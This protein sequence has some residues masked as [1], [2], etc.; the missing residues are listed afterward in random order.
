MIGLL[1]VLVGSGCAKLSDLESVIKK[2]SIEAQSQ[3]HAEESHKFC[4]DQIQKRDTHFTIPLFYQAIEDSFSSK[5]EVIKR[6]EK[7]HQILVRFFLKR[8]AFILKKIGQS[9]KSIFFEKNKS[10]LEKNL[11]EKSREEQIELMVDAM[12]LED[13]SCTTV[14]HDLWITQWIQIFDPLHTNGKAKKIQDYYRVPKNKIARFSEN[15]DRYFVAELNLLDS[16]QV[17]LFINE[18]KKKKL[19]KVVLDLRGAVSVT[20]DWILDFVDFIENNF[21][22]RVLIRTNLWTRGW[23]EQ[24][25]YRLVQTPNVWIVGKHQT[26]LGMTRKFCTLGDYGFGCDSFEKTGPDGVGILSHFLVND[27]Q[28]SSPFGSLRRRVSLIRFGNRSL[29]LMKEGLSEKKLNFLHWLLKQNKNFP[30]ALKSD[31]LSDLEE[32]LKE[33]E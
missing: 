30:M 19:K 6:I 3:Y 4:E 26:T 11:K 31:W 8:G 5:E 10:S 20:D 7:A 29:E 23:I 33:F 32:T 25:L 21:F 12:G 15:E 24:A 9:E 27:N 14:F 22:E 16:N 1:I 18:W 17:Q 28:T 13:P 2:V